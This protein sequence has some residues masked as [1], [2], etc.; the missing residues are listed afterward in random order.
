L[1]GILPNIKDEVRLFEIQKQDNRKGRWRNE[2][3]SRETSEADKV[4]NCL[5]GTP[6]IV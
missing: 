1:P 4:G 6:F 2:E 3:E 5:A